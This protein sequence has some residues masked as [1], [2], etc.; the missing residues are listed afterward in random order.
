M[1]K[2]YLLHLTFLLPAEILTRL[3]KMDKP[4]PYVDL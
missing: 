2:V 3:Q 4:R 1:E